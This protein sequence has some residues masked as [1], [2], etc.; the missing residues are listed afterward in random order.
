MPAVSQAQQKAAAMALAAKRGTTGVEK[1][2]GAAKEMYHSMSEKELE[3]FA[4]TK[5][6]D[7]PKKKEEETSMV[8]NDIL[9]EAQKK[10]LRKIINT[11][12][13]EQVQQR[14]RAFIEKYT[15]FIAESATT[16]VVNKVKN[17]LSTRI[18]EEM[19]E[20]REKAAKIC[21]SVILESST[22]I[23]GVR[24]EQEKLVEEFQK[25]APKLI[26]NLAEEKAKELA[27]DSIDAISEKERLEEAFTGLVKG[28]EK[29]GFVI[30]EDID[31]VI[32]K[33]KNEKLMLRT[34]LAQANRDIKVAQL[35]EGMLPAQKREIETLLED[36]TTDQMVEERFLIAKKKVMENNTVIEEEV[37]N[38]G[39]EKK[40]VAQKVMEEEEMFSS[41]LG[42][43][44]KLVNAS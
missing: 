21:R 1:L 34:K 12:V 10:E 23:R 8:D 33:E 35:T 17:K 44:R 5:R 14:N 20:I 27:S 2:K 42:A 43:A 7:L 41:F 28:M 13:E 15:K 32:Q 24:K 18:D 29:A 26:K 6:S 4:K 39:Q 38:E 37:S 11:L 31:K 19:S 16:K 36:C 25:T 3:D 40:A 30:N 22:K 9:T